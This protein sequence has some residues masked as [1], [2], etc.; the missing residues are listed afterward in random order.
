MKNF[1]KLLTAFAFVM[2]ITSCEEENDFNYVLFADEAPTEVETVVTVA[3]DN[4]GLVT[5]APVAKGVSSF[6]ILFG[7]PDNNEALIGRNLM[8][9]NVYPEGEYTIRIIAISPN[10]KTTETTETIFVERTA[11]LNV[12]SGLL[13]SETAREIE[14]TPVADNATRFEIDFGDGTTEIINAGDSIRHTYVDGGDFLINIIASNPDNGKSNE[15]VQGISIPVEPLDLRLTFDDP[16]TDY[17]F[18]DFNGLSSEL[19]TNPDLSGTN[20]V[21]SIV[22]AITNAGTAFEGFAYDLPTPIDF[23]SDKKSVSVKVWN[24]TGNTL[25]VTLQFVSGVNGERGVE[26]VA[27]H[28]GSGWETLEF[29][30]FGAVKV[31]IPNDPENSQ[32]I[33]AVGQYAEMVMFIDGPG[34]T[35][36]TFYIDD[37]IQELGEVPVGPSYEFNFENDPLDGS[38]DFG[39]PIQI[40]DN[41]FPGGI[42]T[43]AKVLE[44]VRGPGMFQ[45]SGFNIPLLDLTTDEKVITI[46]LY[47]EVPVPLAVDL[48]VS[49][50]GA[51]SAQV[52]ANHTGSGWEELTFNYAN[53]IRAFEPG[54][55]TNFQAMTPDEIGAYTQIVFIVNGPSDA[56]GTFYM[57]DIIKP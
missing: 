46:K 9:T 53:A 1:L 44:I 51:R 21:E 25:P 5:V 16:L 30:F 35:Q 45:G 55:P 18:N 4:S 8:A 7:D 57:D 36:G 26:V 11:I 43:S 17:E 13:I 52:T 32:P 24:D 3:Q 20:D 31:F 14:L 50:A 47:S 42:N 15:I 37:I 49:P 34:S 27:N 12:E 39:A 2:A 38:F 56:T 28:T 41:P 22:A 29:D 10:D 19:V 6:R 48:K 23:G 40:I 54:D 33:T